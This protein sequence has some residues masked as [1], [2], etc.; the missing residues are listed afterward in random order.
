MKYLKITNTSDGLRLARCLIGS[1]VYRNRPIDVTLIGTAN[2]GA[3]FY[4]E[5]NQFLDI[6]DNDRIIVDNTNEILLLIDTLKLDPFAAIANGVS[7]VV[8]FGIW[9]KERGIIG[10][11]CKVFSSMLSGVMNKYPVS[12]NIEAAAKLKGVEVVEL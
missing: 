11:P 2:N 5:Y 7:I 12:L 6:G 4:Y 8:D 9:G 10:Y 3:R 1:P